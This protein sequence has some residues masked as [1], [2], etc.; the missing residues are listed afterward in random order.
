MAAGTEDEH[1]D[2]SN[3]Q[4]AMEKYK[5]EHSGK[6]HDM[7]GKTLNLVATFEDP[8]SLREPLVMKKIWAWS[9]TSEI[10]PY[11]ACE[12]AVSVKRGA[13]R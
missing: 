9:P 1:H 7:D 4:A 12:P 3:F 13:G 8:W 10:A 6:A 11:D 5:R 2:P